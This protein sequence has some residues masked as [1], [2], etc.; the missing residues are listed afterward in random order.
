MQIA[1]Y[2]DILIGVLP[3][4]PLLTAP[5]QIYV[6]HDSD[7]EALLIGIFVDDEGPAVPEALRSALQRMDQE[8]TEHSVRQGYHKEKATGSWPVGWHNLM[9]GLDDDGFASLIAKP[10]SPLVN[11]I[12]DEVRD[13]L[14]VLETAYVKAFSPMGPKQKSK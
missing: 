10:L 14:K 13:Y 12:C 4:N 9:D 3:R 1:G 11:K 8:L 5:F 7:E 2:G 6:E